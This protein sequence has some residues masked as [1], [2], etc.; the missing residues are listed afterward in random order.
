MV[1]RQPAPGAMTDGTV[2]RGVVTDDDGLLRIL[3]TLTRLDENEAALLLASATPDGSTLRELVGLV[4]QAPATHDDRLALLTLID[5]KAGEW[6]PAAPSVVAHALRS[7]PPRFP[8]AAREVALPAVTGQLEG[9]MRTLFDLEET[10]P[11]PWTLV[12]G[13]A[14][15][16]HCIE[17]GRTGH[18]GHGRR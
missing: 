7:Q 2:P 8:A 6:P 13:L 14:V 17:H 4:R 18:A 3:V 11:G 9:A 16:L 12:G 1:A 10:V 15:M 5:T